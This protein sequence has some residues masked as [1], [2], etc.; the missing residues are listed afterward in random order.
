MI[1]AI[2]PSRRAVKGKKTACCNFLEF[3]PIKFSTLP[4]TVLNNAFYQ[5]SHARLGNP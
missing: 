3:N 2:N 1:K 4:G 5:H